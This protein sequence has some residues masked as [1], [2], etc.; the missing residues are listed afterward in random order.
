MTDNAIPIDDA[1]YADLRAYCDRC[2]IRFVDF[3]EDA[4]C[5][6]IDREQILTR[7]V[8]A[9][10]A[11]KQLDQ[12]RRRSYRRGFYQGFVSGVLAG[13]GQLALSQGI[14]PSE[15]CEEENPFKVVA[16]RQLQLFD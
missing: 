11:M 16:G 5:N 1:L 4:L 3:I 14:M 8:E 13:R 2:G 6:A 10:K 9:E 7:S 12:D 15:I